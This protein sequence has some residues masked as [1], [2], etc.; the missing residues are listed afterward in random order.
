MLPK[1]FMTN[2]GIMLIMSKGA[3]RSKEKGFGSLLVEASSKKGL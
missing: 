3:L 1:Q 2:N